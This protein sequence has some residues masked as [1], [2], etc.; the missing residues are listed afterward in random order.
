VFGVEREEGGEE[1][2]EG[3]FGAG[4]W[5]VAAAGAEEATLVAGRGTTTAVLVTTGAE[6]VVAAGDWANVPP[7]LSEP[8]VLPELAR[9]ESTVLVSAATASGVQELGPVA[10]PVSLFAM[11]EA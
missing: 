11:S 2:G 1:G 9:L 8:P 6:L 7:V 4:A 3:L 10:Q 5:V